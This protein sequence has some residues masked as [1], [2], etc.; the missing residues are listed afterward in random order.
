MVAIIVVVVIT[1]NEETVTYSIICRDPI[2]P[3]FTHHQASATTKTKTIIRYAK[4]PIKLYLCS[5]AFLFLY[6]E[7]QFTL[8][9]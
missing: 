4:S 9:N 8:K 2:S 1:V 6:Y 5:V 3:G 7:K